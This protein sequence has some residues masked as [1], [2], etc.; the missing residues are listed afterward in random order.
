MGSSMTLAPEILKKISQKVAKTCSE[1]ERLKKTEI[2]VKKVGQNL[3][4]NGHLEIRL[5]G[6]LIGRTSSEGAEHVFGARNLD[7]NR[8]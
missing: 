2:F 8:S 4:R 7:K 6:Q 1:T 3:Q 5:P